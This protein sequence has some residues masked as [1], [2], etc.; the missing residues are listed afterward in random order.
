MQ[1]LQVAGRAVLATGGDLATDGQ[2]QTS[3]GLTAFAGRSESV[4]SGWLLFQSG[5]NMGQVGTVQFVLN[6][7]T[8]F[9]S[10]SFQASA[11][12]SFT[13]VQ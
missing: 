5:P 13:L 6:P 7:T 4:I 2:R 11:N 12:Q 3:A 8:F 10:E 1:P 9:T